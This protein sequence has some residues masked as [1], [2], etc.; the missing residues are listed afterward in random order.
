M[1]VLTVFEHQ[2]LRVGDSFNNVIFTEELRIKLEKHYGSDG[3]PYFNLIHKGV[4]FKEYVG[5]IQLG[6][7]LIE[8][9]P[10]TD[11][12]FPET[13]ENYWRNMLIQMLQ[14]TRS[15]EVHSTGSGHHKLKPNAILDL[16]FELF[17]SEVEYLIHSGLKKKYRK[18]NSNQQ[19]LKG[20]L[21]FPKHVQQNLIRQDRFF[22]NHTNYDAEHLLHQILFETIVLIKTVSLSA[23]H[24]SRLSNIILHFPELK[25][26][27]VTSSTFDT[28]CLNR[29]TEK[30]RKALEI[31]KLL[32]LRYHPDVSNGSNH[33]M[34]LMFNMNNLWEEFIY[35]TVKIMMPDIKV[36]AQQS[37]EFWQHSNGRPTRLIPDILIDYNSKKYILDTK[38]KNLRDR[39]PSPEDLRQMY[40]YSE[41][42]NAHRVTLIY[43]G[44]NTHVS[45]KYY[46]SDGKIHEYK[47]CNLLQLDIDLHFKNWQKQIVQTIRDLVLV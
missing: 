20:A 2:K 28:I 25:R 27:R 41:Y 47:S 45:G 15:L 23:R 6:K 7:T 5:V 31:S 29:N 44:N 33:V 32:H 18:Q 8:V 35:K 1:K 46:N 10:K 17:I 19:S 13:S 21:H 34:S 37:K 43:P 42:F 3:V 14:F 39:N 16:Y 9:L 38:W 11:S 30:Y 22:V 24:K 26:I 4:H 40:V 12:A 36:K